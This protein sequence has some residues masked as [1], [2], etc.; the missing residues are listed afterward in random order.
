MTNR[1]SASKR[2][3]DDISGL[4][5][6][7]LTKL[8]ASSINAAT[9]KTT[10][11]DADSFAMADSAASGVLKK[12]T[13]TNLKTVLATWLNT[14]T[15]TW[16]NKTLSAPVLASFASASVNTSTSTLGMTN[17]S[18][19]IQLITGSTAGFVVTLPTTGINVGKHHLIVNQSSVSITVNAS[20]GGLV[21]TMA[22]GTAIL[23]E[24]V[25][26]TPTTAAGWTWFYTGL[27]VA[28]R[29]TTSISTATT[30]AV[31][32]N[33]LYTYFLT[34][35]AAVPTVPT[36]VSSTAE[37]TI[38]NTHTAAITVLTTSSQT[39]SGQTS[40]TLQPNE[41]ITLVSNNAN[42]WIV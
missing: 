16:S 7:L 24:A 9:A 41:S 25:A 34:A 22:P 2:P 27:G 31:A 29:V 30:L 33:T 36:A 35:L 23:I 10:P 17:S 4:V 39:I 19:H 18:T 13:L 21:Q 5:D 11:V 6:A 37:Y 28:S 32:P 1:R 8:D 3:Q 40:Y 14:L 26:A 15:A 38:I 12:V 42:W 20:G